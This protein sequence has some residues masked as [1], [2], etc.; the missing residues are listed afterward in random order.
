M[1]KKT[2]TTRDDLK[3]FSVMFPTDIL[4]ELDIICKNQC[5]SRSTW[6]LAALREKLENDRL[7]KIE[8]F[9]ELGGK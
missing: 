6:L 3:Q 4:E 9:R 5:M 2:R 7:R 1:T 8:K